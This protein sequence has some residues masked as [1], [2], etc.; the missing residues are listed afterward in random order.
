MLVWAVALFLTV[1]DSWLLII[2][3]F[4]LMSPLCNTPA[5]QSMHAAAT[6][7]D[8]FDGSQLRS[9]TPHLLFP[10]PPSPPHTL[11]EK[12]N[13]RKI[14]STNFVAIEASCAV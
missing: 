2:I 1:I 4:E 14:A 10:N 12:M 5:G 3:L 7:K 9:T 11:K 13:L 6:T 8:I